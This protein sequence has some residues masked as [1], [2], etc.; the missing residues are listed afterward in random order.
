MLYLLGL[1][2]THSHSLQQLIAAAEKYDV[3]DQLQDM[4]VSCIVMRGETDS[5][6]DEALTK[7]M[8]QRIIGSTMITTPGGHNWILQNPS[9]L[10]RYLD[11]SYDGLV[12]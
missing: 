10:E 8:H 3:R 6:M 4:D 2:H 1:Q 9:I 7:G 12:S 11:R 5:F